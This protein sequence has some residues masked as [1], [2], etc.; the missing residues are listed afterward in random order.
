GLTQKELAAKV[1]LSEGSVS[2]YEN[3][4]VEDATNTK[5]NEFAQALGVDIGWLLGLEVRRKHKSP[6]LGHVHAGI[7]IEAI[8]NI[9]DYEEISPA[10]ASTG[11]YFALRIAGSSMEP[12]ICD[13]DVVIVRKQSDIESGEVAIVM[14]NGCDATCKKVVKHENGL[15]LVSFNAVYEPKFFTNDEI[16]SMPITILGRVEELRG[17]F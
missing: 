10:M 8:E 15:S 2:K 1:S 12:R 3:G 4:K 14:V 13:G 11:E 7:P 17:K 5:L 9:L 6:V 16:L